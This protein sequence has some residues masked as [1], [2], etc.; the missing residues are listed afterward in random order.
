MCLFLVLLPL[1]LNQ[2]ECYF[3][4]ATLSTNNF[5]KLFLDKTSSNIIER[6]IFNANFFFSLPE[7]ESNEQLLR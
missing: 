7:C 6:T 5:K 3:Y 4:V 1:S 2:F